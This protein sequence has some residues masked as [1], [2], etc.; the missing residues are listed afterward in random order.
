MAKAFSVKN[1]FKKIHSHELVA[2]F[3]E[4]HGIVAILGI[5]DTTARKNA[6]DLMMDFYKSV[7]PVKKIDIEKEL[8]LIGTLSTKY[9]VALFIALLKQ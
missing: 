5:T 7:E 3:Y 4:T 2:D 9:S 8:A 1:Y 6:V